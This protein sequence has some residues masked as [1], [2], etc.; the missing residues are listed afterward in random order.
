MV[1]ENTGFVDAVIGTEVDI[2][3][4]GGIDVLT[5]GCGEAVSVG[6]IADEGVGE[7]IPGDA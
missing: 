3:D 6:E 2:G 5:D 4:K 1:T 7:L